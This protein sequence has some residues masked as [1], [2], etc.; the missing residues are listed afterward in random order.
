[1]I[2]KKLNNVFYQ[3]R[4][5]SIGGIETFYYYLAKKYGN[6]IVYYSEGDPLQI[7]RLSKYVP[8]RKWNKEKIKCKN[9]F[10]TFNRDILDYAEYDNLFYMVHGDYKELHKQPF[11]GEATFL[12][13]SDNSK[14][15]YEEISGLKAI[16]WQNPIC[17]DPPPRV[18]RLISTTRLTKEKGGERMI[19][20]GQMMDKAGIKYT[21][22]IYTND[23]LP[24][25]ASPNMVIRKPTLDILPFIKAADYLVQ[26]S[27]SEGCCYAVAEALG[28]GTAVITTDLP[29]FRE[30]GVEG[31]GYF[32]TDTLPDLYDIPQFPPFVREDRW[33]E[34]LQGPRLE[35][36]PLVAVKCIYPYQDISRG[37]TRQ[38]DI[39]N[40]S[41]DRAEKLKEKNLVEVL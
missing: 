27:S 10:I 38:G 1:M 15:S 3:Q 39:Y 35:T 7:A 24:R 26:L 12:C 8:V 41:P 22:D 40:V 37:F 11:K 33:G 31:R 23:N 14:R 16:T 25:E 13:V 21:W 4:F 32:F 2:Q 19:K 6:F 36:D 17:I 20:L 29:T 9:L 28:V 18:L 34:L 30:Q 5:G